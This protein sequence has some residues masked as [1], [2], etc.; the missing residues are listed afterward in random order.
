MQSSYIPIV[1]A[2]PVAQDLAVECPEFIYKVLVKTVRIPQRNPDVDK[3]GQR[4]KPAK[5]S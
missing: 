4:K 5:D 1:K 2:S 3:E